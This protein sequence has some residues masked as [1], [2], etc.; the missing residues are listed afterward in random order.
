M[1]ITYNILPLSPY[2]HSNRH[3]AYT[4]MPYNYRQY[5]RYFQNI[6][7]LV[8]KYRLLERTCRIAGPNN[9]QLFK[10]ILTFFVLTP[11]LC[12]PQRLLKVAELCGNQIYSYLLGRIRAYM[13]SWRGVFFNLPFYFFSCLFLC[14]FHVKSHLEI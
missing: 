14:Y 11:F 12:T 4:P 13:L 9:G 6:H 5:P 10:I 3:V 8:K 7:Q 2:R 1:S